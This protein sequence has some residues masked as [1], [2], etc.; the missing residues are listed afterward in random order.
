LIER[1]WLPAKKNTLAK[2]RKQLAG[3][4]ALVDFWWQT[5]GRDLE[6]MALPRVE[7]MGGRLLAAADVLAG[8]LSRKRCPGQKGQIAL[9]S[10]PFKTL[11]DEASCTQRLHPRCWQ[12]GKGGRRAR[13]QAFQRASF[14]RLKVAMALCRRC[15][16]IIAA[17]RASQHGMDGRSTIRLSRLGWNDARFTIFQAGFPDP[18]VKPVLAK[19][20][21]LPRPRQRHQA[22]RYK[23]LMT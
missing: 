19:I 2:V 22:M 16:I 3:L 1:Q 9:A 5:V 17:C 18:V 21:D 23:W 11:F 7:T 6:H 10:G 14:Q 13:C 15:S 8:A 20:E 4:S 12:T